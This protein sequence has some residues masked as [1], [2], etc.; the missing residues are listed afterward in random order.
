M[1]KRRINQF[2]LTL[3]IKPNGPLLIKSGLDSAADPTLPQMSFVRTQHPHGGE[4]VYLPGSSLKGVIRSH[5]ERILRTVFPN[6]R[7]K[8]C[9]PLERGCEK[10]ADRKTGSAAVYKTSC[11]A[12]RI[13]G[14]TAVGSHFF[15]NDA[16]PEVPLNN[17][18]L[19]HNVAINRR[20]G[21]AQRGALFDM[22]V[23]VTG[24][25]QTTLYLHNFEL[26]QIGLLA[27]ALRD[28]D[29]GHVRIGFAK[30]RGLGAVHIDFNEAVL[31]YTTLAGA[32]EETY[33]SHIYGV[34]TAMPQSGAETASHYG[35]QETDSQP[36]EQGEV[37]AD[38]GNTFIKATETTDIQAL[39][40]AGVAAW[41]EMLQA[42]E[43]A[44]N[45]GN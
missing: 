18:E 11:L 5:S 6:N 43:P 42:P 3:T 36:Y 20:N 27:L 14:S 2:A 34:T 44:V 32:Q 39:F 15:I 19:R 24:D 1:H 33:K 31:Q 45:G 38:W 40:K 35:F 28:I 8:C 12:C 7:H 21:A 29:A 9:D 10:E 22:E 16:Y 26:W 13:Y 4:T 25:F 23:A 37:T 30:S 17:L 41:Q